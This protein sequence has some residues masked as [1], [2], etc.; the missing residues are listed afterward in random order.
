MVAEDHAFWSEMGCPVDYRQLPGPMA[1][2][3]LAII[4]GKGRK[5][6]EESDK[7]DRESKKAKRQA[8]GNRYT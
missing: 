1:S 8:K 3:H 7:A 4:E 5:S 6:R 2:A